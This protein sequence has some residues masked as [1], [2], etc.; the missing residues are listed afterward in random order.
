[1][2]TR[3]GPDPHSPQQRAVISGQQQLVRIAARDQ[4]SFGIA[5]HRDLNIAPINQVPLSV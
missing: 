2:A 5:L 3:L 4:P 1:M